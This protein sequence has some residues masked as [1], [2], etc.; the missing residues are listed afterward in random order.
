MVTESGFADVLREI[1]EYRFIF[2]RGAPYH[3]CPGSRIKHN[4]DRAGERDTS[5]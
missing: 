2:A 5:K 3:E 4:E 1:V